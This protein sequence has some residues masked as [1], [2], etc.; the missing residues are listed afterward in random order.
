VVSV[1]IL[2]FNKVVYLLTMNWLISCDSRT[3]VSQ[4]IIS[5]IIKIVK[6]FYK[7]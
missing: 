1:L 5:S 3:A 7:L 4:R 2:L 6:I